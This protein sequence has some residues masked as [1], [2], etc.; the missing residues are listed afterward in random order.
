MT[1]G[2]D[3][4]LPLPPVV[5]LDAGENV[6]AGGELFL[7]NGLRNGAC[8]VDSRGGDEDEARGEGHGSSYFARMISVTR[9]R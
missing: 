8:F 3:S 7:E 5:R 1:S 6:D 2:A 9:A 4:S